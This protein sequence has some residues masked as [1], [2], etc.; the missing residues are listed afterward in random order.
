[1]R[2]MLG[3]IKEKVAL[4]KSIVQTVTRSVY[5]VVSKLECL[6]T[7]AT[8][9]IQADQNNVSSI[10]NNIQLLCPIKICFSIFSDSCKVC[11]EGVYHLDH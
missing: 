9:L 5:L 8:I 11:S 1:M 3:F 6:T 4:N 2:K 10:E 7:T